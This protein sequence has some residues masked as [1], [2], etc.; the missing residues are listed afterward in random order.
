[1]VDASITTPFLGGRGENSAETSPVLSCQQISPTL[2]IQKD[3]SIKNL[4]SMTIGGT[5][6]SSLS[7]G[8]AC[9]LDSHSFKFSIQ[10]ATNANIS[11]AP[12]EENGDM[13]AHKQKARHTFNSAS[14]IIKPSTRND[15]PFPSLSSEIV[16][17]SL[18]AAVSTSLPST[19]INS[20]CVSPREC[21]SPRYTPSDSPVQVTPDMYIPGIAVVHYN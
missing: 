12:I 16:S 3:G 4:G 19:D 14:A 8:L 7:L 13:T 20:T 17:T 6:T 10:P 21:Q 18:F 15:P 9:G 11:H 2:F 1:V 5:E